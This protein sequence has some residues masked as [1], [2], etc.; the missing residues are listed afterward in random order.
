MLRDVVVIGSGISGLSCAYELARAGASVEIVARSLPPATT[1]NIAAAFWYPY[2][3]FPRARVLSWAARSWQRFATLA[4]TP[5][6]GVRMAEAVE[7]VRDASPPRPWWCDSAANVRAAPSDGLPDGMAAAWR[8]VAPIVDTRKYMPWLVHAVAALGVRTVQREVRQ[9]SDLSE[10]YRGAVVVD[11]AGLGARELVPD[12]AVEPIRGQLVLVENPGLSRVL[13]DE[14]NPAGVTYVVPRGDD[15]VLG[16]TT[17]PGDDDQR[18]RIADRDAVLARCIA[19]EPRLAGARLLADVV[20][21]RPGRASV[22]LDHTPAGPDQPAVVHN[23]GH[24]GAGVT[25]SWGCA[26]AVAR[27]VAQEHPGMYRPAA[28]AHGTLL[29]APRR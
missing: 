2:F 3:A 12:P 10:A 24:G 20:G 25:L 28:F 19:L 7:F 18:T 8:F 15:C 11:C 29:G 23:Y 6:T 9:L 26:E 13:L 17:H 16:G 21:L 14:T 27:L 5:A 22:R 1:S 4:E